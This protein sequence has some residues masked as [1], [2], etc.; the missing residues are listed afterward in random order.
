MILMSTLISLPLVL[1]RRH[2]QS[3]LIPMRLVVAA[4][5]IVF[6]VY[7]AWTLGIKL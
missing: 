6:G 7:Y 3:M 1:T 2:L 5:S 4:S